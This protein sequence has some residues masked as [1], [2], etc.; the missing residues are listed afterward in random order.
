VIPISTH[1]KSNTYLPISSLGNELKQNNDDLYALKT[2]SPEIIW[3]FG[4]KIKI[5]NENNLNSLL[6]ESTLNIIIQKRNDDIIKTLQQDYNLEFIKTYNLNTVSED[7]RSYK[8]RLVYNYY[9]IT[10]K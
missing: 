2:P 8:N 1:L 9:K 5:I 10:Q 7:E 3:S 6:N 4:E